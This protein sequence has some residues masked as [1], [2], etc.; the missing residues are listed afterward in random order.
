MTGKKEWRS[1]QKAAAAEEGRG[2]VDFEKQEVAEREEE[3]GARR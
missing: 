2:K 3:E 1:S